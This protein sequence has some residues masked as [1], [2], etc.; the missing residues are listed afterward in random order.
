MGYAIVGM[1]TLL[2]ETLEEEYRGRAFAAIQVIM[3]ASI[4][5]SII[6]AGPLADLITAM[7]RWI[8]FDPVSFFI[9]RM[10]GS[11]AGEIDGA[12]ADFRFLFNG[13]Q[14][15]LLIG[16]IVILLAGIYGQRAFHKYFEDV[17]WD[18]AYTKEVA[19]GARAVGQAALVTTTAATSQSE[20]VGEEGGVMEDIEEEMAEVSEARQSLE[21]EMEEAVICEEE[22]EEKRSVW[23]RIW[24]R[25]G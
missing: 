24:R 1:I 22:G 11:Y 23:R 2:M 10:G 3:R 21:R 7:G 12:T 14:L 9:F 19:E 6:I 18:I 16:G 20:E 4:F 17:G 25:K 13:P 5:I 15:I 8:G